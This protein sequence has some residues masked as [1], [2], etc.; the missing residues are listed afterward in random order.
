MKLLRGHV[1]GDGY[2]ILQQHIAGVQPCIHQ[3]GGNTGLLLTVDDG[4]VNRCRSP[5]TWQ[6]GGVDIDAAQPW[7]VQN[8]LGQNLPES[9]Y[10]DEVRLHF[11]QPCRKFLCLDFF[12]LQYRQT[13]LKSRLLHRRGLKVMPPAL[14]PVRLGNHRHNICLFLQDMQA[15]YGKI[16]R[17]HE[18]RFQS[19]HIVFY[20][21]IL[22]LGDCAWLLIAAH[23]FP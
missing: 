4:P 6:Q 11:L 23:N 22:P 16:R 14:W 2:L 21:L 7:D 19:I 18:N 10:Y 8:P 12:R 3:H 5:V 9:H 13:V 15:G 1:R 20:L 17:T